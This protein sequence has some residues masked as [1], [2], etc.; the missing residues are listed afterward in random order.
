[1]KKITFTLMIFTILL[2]L[3]SFAL[4][5]WNDRDR[6]RAQ[7][8]QTTEQ[9]DCR[10]PSGTSFGITT[11]S[12]HSDAATGGCKDLLKDHITSTWSQN[13]RFD[14]VTWSEVTAESNIYAIEYILYDTVFEQN[15]TKSSSVQAIYLGTITTEECPSP[16]ENIKQ[17]EKFDVAKDWYRNPVEKENG[18]IDC[19]S[20]NQYQEYQN[21][22]NQNNNNSSR[23]KACQSS[24][25]SPSASG[26]TSACYYNPSS[27]TT[28]NYEAVTDQ[29][30]TI[31]SMQGTES[32]TFCGQDPNI[33]E[34]EP[35]LPSDGDGNYVENPN[36]EKCTFYSNKY[37]CQADK[38]NHCESVNGTEICDDG[39]FQS[40]DAFLCDPNRHPDAAGGD[41]SNYND[42]S[43]A[44]NLGTQYAT[45]GFCEKAGGLW[46]NASQDASTTC[47]N[48]D[49]YNGSCSI[50]QHSF[51]CYTCSDA[52][53]SWLSDGKSQADTL[54]D[55]ETW[56]QKNNEKLAEL[57]NKNQ[58]ILEETKNQSTLTKN[59]IDSNVADTNKLKS[60]IDALGTNLGQSINAT[61]TKLDGIKLAIENQ[62]SSNDD[63]IEQFDLDSAKAS[64]TT[65]FD[66]HKTEYQTELD[67]IKDEP[68]L[69]KVNDE[70]S[71]LFG[72]ETI[73][74]M[75]QSFQSNTCQNPSISLPDSVG[76][77]S[78]DMDF[79][80][81]APLIKEFFYW[82]L[83]I[84]TAMSLIFKV[85]EVI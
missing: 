29:S 3:K 7:E 52:G 25:I 5:F 31:T 20:D 53:G 12:N 1:M 48:Q 60:S 59:L 19:L 6:P 39:C 54:A 27:G 8:Q 14:F 13:D 4:D 42:T 30:G 41:S 58:Q 81:K 34:Y 67:K 77:A 57:S 74:S 51:S 17:H 18:Q 22:Q 45:K 43:G 40:G 11:A 26:Q 49:I 16:N 38:S 46:S 68:N 55:G 21:K 47:N 44:C 23:D 35:P 84:L 33:P 62:E 72:F 83:P 64:I 66:N 73:N 37:Y 82:L 78:Y 79:C 10:K 76:G 36:T 32:A 69:Q 28:C 24:I 70:A 15:Q 56:E 9:Y 71:T 61:N 65:A 50:Q 63:L 85:R 80:D 75:G 2:P